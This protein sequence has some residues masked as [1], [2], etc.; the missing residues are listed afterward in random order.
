MARV[1]AL[2]HDCQFFQD[3]IAEALKRN[4]LQ[5]AELY[6]NCSAEE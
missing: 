4:R 5:R 3:A 2:G 1:L 6:R